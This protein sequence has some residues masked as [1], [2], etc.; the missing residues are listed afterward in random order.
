MAS[1]G[2]VSRF[3]HPCCSW[4]TPTTCPLVHPG[5]QR[6]PLLILEMQYSA[7]AHLFLCVLWGIICIL[8]PPSQH[9]HF[10]PSTFGWALWD[11]QH[12]LDAPLHLRSTL[13]GNSSI[14]WFYIPNSPKSTN[15][16]LTWSILPIWPFADSLLGHTISYSSFGKRVLSSKHL[17]NW[18]MLWSNSL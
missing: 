5:W 9:A 10:F 16:S 13:V 4:Q 15:S 3:C 17:D 12:D 14:S 1:V 6:R 8:L 7:M 2:L 18:V 11:F